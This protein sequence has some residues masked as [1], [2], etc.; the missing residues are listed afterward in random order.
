MF[1]IIKQTNAI[2]RVI[3]NVY[4]VQARCQC[5]N[6]KAQNCGLTTLRQNVLVQLRCKYGNMAAEMF[7]A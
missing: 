2:R 4:A 3:I 5:R 1:S 6:F 7:Q